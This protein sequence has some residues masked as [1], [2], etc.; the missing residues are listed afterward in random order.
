M[1][2]DIRGLK[3]PTLFNKTVQLSSKVKYLGLTL[4]KGLTWKNSWIG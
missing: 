4:N 1:K 3:E 2:R